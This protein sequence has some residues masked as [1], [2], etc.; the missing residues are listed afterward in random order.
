MAINIAERAEALAG[1]LLCRLGR[2]AAGPPFMRNRDHRFAR[3]FRCD[4]D[5]VRSDG[6]WHRPK[7]YRIVWPDDCHTAAEIPPAAQPQA[8]A[9][10]RSD[11]C[12]ETRREQAAQALLAILDSLGNAEPAPV[13]APA[14]E[15][16]PIAAPPVPP[17]RLAPPTPVPLAPAQPIEHLADAAPPEVPD[18]EVTAP[19]RSALPSPP[20]PV[21][22]A[23]AG[24][25]LLAPHAAA[26][27][28]DFMSDD[29][30]DHFDWES[31]PRPAPTGSATTV[32]SQPSH[33]EEAPQ[34]KAE[35]RTLLAGEVPRG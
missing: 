29:E 8:A 1:L 10:D 35:R 27:G 31:S 18:P 11:D 22:V 16:K 9:A 4:C 2:H 30:S 21:P 23:D 14:P 32:R 19:G 25:E 33:R 12:A 15:A 5:L 28:L 3:C 34:A 6:P 24:P 13:P 17:P 26:S 7:G 20:E